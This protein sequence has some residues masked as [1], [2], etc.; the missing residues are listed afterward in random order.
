MLSLSRMGLGDTA[1]VLARAAT[2]DQILTGIGTELEDVAS[3]LVEFP[4]VDGYTPA[5]GEEEIAAGFEPYEWYEIERIF[6]LNE[7]K[8]IENAILAT[9]LQLNTASLRS[10]LRS[11]QAW[12][13]LP[14]ETGRPDAVPAPLLRKQ[15]ENLLRAYDEMALGRKPRGTTNIWLIIG[16]TLAGVAVLGGVA[17]YLK[18][19]R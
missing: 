17:L 1:S 16:G 9:N 18:K 7:R 8:A 15:I 4:D 13:E 3:G 12:P 5:F 10:F 14:P 2:A 11:R 6:F 19:R